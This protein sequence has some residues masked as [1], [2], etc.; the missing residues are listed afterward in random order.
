MPHPN[1]RLL[2]D[3]NR[4]A[5]LNTIREHSPIARTQIAQDLQISIP[6]VMR[7]VGDLV[8][9]GLVLE[10]DEYE[11]T[12]GR[13]RPLLA[14]NASASL[15][16]GVDLGGAEMVGALTDLAGVIQEEER[17]PFAGN[18]P[19]ENVEKLCALIGRLSAT[20]QKLGNKIRM[21]GVGVP[22]VTLRDT[23][24]V[25][26]APGLGWRDYPLLEILQER[27]GL[28][29][30]LENDA[31]LAAL[32]E[33]GF[34]AGKGMKNMVLL[35]IGRGLGAGLIL[36]GQLYRGQHSAAGE[37]GYLAPGVEY[38]RSPHD[39]FGALESIASELGLIRRAQSFFKQKD[40]LAQPP[41]L[42]S[43]SIFRAASEG[44]PWAVQAVSETTDFLSLAIATLST[45]LDP[46]VIVLGGSM[47]YGARGSFE[48][49][50]LGRIRNTLPAAAPLAVS[51]L[52]AHAAALGAIMMVVN[53]GSR[54]EAVASMAS[55]FYGKWRSD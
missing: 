4:S 37:I 40:V 12:G 34:G 52:G 38:L 33:W 45:I 26:W 3:I 31:N 2:R 1:S 18:A 10:L 7:V 55:I 16:I 24:V 13:P 22:G 29:V 27:L 47:V 5:I 11:Y 8:A 14:Y 53:G 20:A 19:E 44:K 36:G 23:G 30:F 48:N 25:V 46:E 32:G 50:V 9:E 51:S 6:T 28:P 21:V 49:L 42:T 41:E 39:T 54:G 35:A 15:V 17:Q 43:A